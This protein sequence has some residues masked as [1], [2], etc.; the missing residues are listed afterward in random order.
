MRDKSLTTTNTLPAPDA[1]LSTKYLGNLDVAALP[2]DRSRVFE[3]TGS[4][5]SWNNLLNG[6]DAEHLNVFGPQFQ[7]SPDPLMF[8]KRSSMPLAGDSRAVNYL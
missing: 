5:Y 2:I 7:P 4:S 3:T 6:Q 1:V 8:D